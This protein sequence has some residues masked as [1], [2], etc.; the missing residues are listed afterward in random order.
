MTD[1]ALMQFGHVD[2][3]GRPMFR[4]AASQQGELV[5]RKPGGPLDEGLR[6]LE[7]EERVRLAAIAS[8]RPALVVESQTGDYVV[9]IDRTVDLDQ[10]VPLGPAD[11]ELLA[12]GPARARFGRRDQDVLTLTPWAEEDDVSLFDPEG[13]AFESVPLAQLD[14]GGALTWLRGEADDELAQRVAAELEHVGAEPGETYGVLL[15]PFGELLC[16]REGEPLMPHED[17]RRQALIGTDAV[18]NGARS[19]QDAAA[20]LRALADR[21]EGAQGQGWRLSHPVADGIAF[22]E[23]DL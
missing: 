10:H 1:S 2:R 19:L 8:D 13:P 5:L 22:A 4:I 3:T 16:V 6:E 15:N 20:R 21:L 7:T 11:A 23:R 18:L 9:L 12:R 14:D 17:V